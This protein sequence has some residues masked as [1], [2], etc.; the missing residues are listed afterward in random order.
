MS[1]SAIAVLGAGS[2]GTALAIHLARC[3]HTVN[4]W[5]HREAH[6]QD[7]LTLRQ[8]ARFLPGIP[9]PASLTPCVDLSVAVESAD[10]LLL[11]IPSRGFRGLVKQLRDFPKIP[12][13][14]ATKGFDPEGDLLSHTIHE[15]LGDSLDSAVISGPT[16]A[17]EV[18]QGKHTA[19][20]IASQSPEFLSRLSNDFHSD[21]FRV[22]SSADIV[23]VQVG[24]AVKNVLAI[25]AG[26]ADGSDL[27]ANVRSALITR[28]LTE[29]M[30]LGEAMG[31]CK[32]TFMG[33]AGLGDLVLTCTD[34]QS[35]NR[36]FGV[37]LGQG[38]SIESAMSQ[39]SQVVEGMQTAFEVQKA[40]RHLSIDMPITDQIC[41]LLKG[42]ISA[43][44]AVSAL[45]SRQQKSEY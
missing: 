34:N 15:L 23:G 42:N 41:E 44:D 8:N 20:T 35:R 19:V 30:R 36:R 24:G 32:E 22:Y 6:I 45:F 17:T 39:I 31:G 18:A 40:A 21:Y 14:W 37:C 9:F 29:M 2:W 28:G 5:G 13:V 3:G 25:A 43:L 27:G 26:V 33:L 10:Y 16:F 4:L 1:R 11:S 7:L 12:V 38:G